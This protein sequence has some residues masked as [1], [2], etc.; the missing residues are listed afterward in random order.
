MIMTISELVRTLKINK[1]KQHILFLGAGASVASGMP[2]V[3]TC[4]WLFKR[5]IFLSEHPELTSHDFDISLKIVQNKIQ[6]FL[7]RKNIVPDHGVDEY[8]YYFKKCYSIPEAR[9]SFFQALVAEANPSYGYHIIPLLFQ[10]KFICSLWTTNFDALGA[11]A[12]KDSSIRAIEVGADCVGRLKRDNDSNEFLCVS[13]HGD[14]RYDL[15]R[16]L[17]D[18]LQVNENK[19]LEEFSDYTSRH[20]IIICGYS[21]RDRCVMSSLRKAYACDNPYFVYWCGYGEDDFNAEVQSFIEAVNNSGGHA[22]YVNTQGFDDLL[23]RLGGCV[24]ESLEIKKKYFDII[25]SKKSDNFV[26][27]F[28][29]PIQPVSQLIKANAIEIT[30]PT[31]YWE[32]TLANS[33]YVTWKQCKDFSHNNPFAIVPFHGNICGIGEL[34]AIK[35]V[36]KANNIIIQEIKTTP[37]SD[38]EITYHDG[39]IKNLLLT[40]IVKILANKEN[41]NTDGRCFLWEKTQYSPVNRYGNSLSVYPCYRQVEISL[42]NILGKN[43]IV[44]IPSTLVTS[45]NGEW[46]KEIQ[47]IEFNKISGWQHN[48]I[49]NNDFEYWRKKLFCSNKN[50]FFFQNCSEQ[51]F[52]TCNNSKPLYAGIADNS[53]TLPTEFTKDT[54]GYGIRIPE[55]ELLFGGTEK[56]SNISPIDGVKR[57][58]PYSY[59]VLTTLENKGIKLGI[60][61][62][63]G[64]DAKKLFSFL[65][66]ADEHIKAE[67]THDYIADYPGFSQAFKIA[68]NIPPPNSDRCEYISDNTSVKKLAD[69]ICHAID[70][71]NKRE[72]QDVILIF[73]PQRWG[74]PIREENEQECFDL[75]DFVKSYCAQKGIVTQ[76]IAEKTTPIARQMCRVW[77]WLSLAICGC[78]QK[79]DNLTW[80][81]MPVKLT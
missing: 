68:L 61:T 45:N 52:C 37:L 51:S 26:E 79:L 27:K 50:N 1:T 28:K 40:A 23:F 18:E 67:N 34:S 55:I 9:R 47:K 66:K 11:K 49:Y 59:P 38:S 74:Y 8:S 44:L 60:V 17:A 39:A 10:E 29:L 36:L 53:R 15:L 76:F 14:Y 71:I 57:N 81:K 64:S 62:P 58:G 41:L 70:S 30:I 63:N 7:E 80:C 75:H 48:N 2:M 12:C 54:S 56:T 13:L 32:I 6:S 65:K 31:Q 19:L 78:P 72:G 3:S 16:N 35:N 77:W 21:G 42:S 5:E 22:Y 69:E 33:S 46:D 25:S 20:S 73:L 43:C 4:I 24:I